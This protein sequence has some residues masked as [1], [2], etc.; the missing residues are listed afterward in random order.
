MKSVTFLHL[1]EN[2]TFEVEGK[3]SQ[4]S[5][6][7]TAVTLPQALSLTVYTPWQ[8]RSE[9]SNLSSSAASGWK[10]IQSV[11]VFFFLFFVDPIHLTVVKTS[12]ASNRAQRCEAG[13][14]KTRNEKG[15]IKYAFTSMY[16]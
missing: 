3:K 13:R 16:N 11:F 15:E 6:Y 4:L 14:L 12:P 7:I 1:S 5:T 9:E 10:I 8:L 2:K